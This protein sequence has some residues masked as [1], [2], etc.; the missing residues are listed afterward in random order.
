LWRGGRTHLAGAEVIGQFRHYI[1]GKQ[2]LLLLIR[3]NWQF[4]IDFIETSPDGMADPKKYW[5]N[6]QVSLA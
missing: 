6:G 1:K 5:K 2:S 4:V 3:D